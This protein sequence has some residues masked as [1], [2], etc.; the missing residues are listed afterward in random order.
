MLFTPLG[1]LPG[2]K[3]GPGYARGHGASGHWLRARAAVVNTNTD[4]MSRWRHLFNVAKTNFRATGTTG[5]NITPVNGITPAEA[6]F[7]QSAT[8]LG[9]LVPGLFEGDLQLPQTLSGCSSVEAFE[10]M[11]S[12]ILAQLGFP[13]PIAPAMTVA[14][15]AASGSTVT[16]TAGTAT[17]AVSPAANAQVGPITAIFAAALTISGITVPAPPT[18]PAPAWSTSQT[19]IVQFAMLPNSTAQGNL[20]SPWA[21]LIDEVP[22]QYTIAVTGLPTGVTCALSGIPL[23]GPFWLNSPMV[24]QFSVSAT[25]DAAPGAYQGSMVCTGPGGTIS[26]NFAVTILDPTAYTIGVNF[27]GLPTGAVGELEGFAMYGFNDPSPVSLED[28]PSGTHTTFPLTY[29]ASTNTLTGELYFGVT[30]DPS[31]PAST[32]T[33]SATLAGYATAPTVAPQFTVTTVAVTVGQPCPPFQVATSVAAHTVYD[34]DWNVIGFSLFPTWPSE[35]NDPS[36]PAGYSFAYAW[37]LTASPSYTSGYAVPPASQWRTILSTGPNLPTPQQVLAA[38]EDIF[39]PLPPT[40]KMKI[41]FQWVDPLT[42]APGPQATKTLSWAQGTN[43]GA[44]TPQQGWPLPAFSVSTITPGILAPGSTQVTLTV[45]AGYNYTGAISFSVAAASYINTGTPPGADT[46][47]TGLTSSFDNPVINFVNGVPDHASTTLTLSAI[48]GAQQFSGEIDVELTDSVVSERVY[49]T[50]TIAGVTTPQPL[51]NFL[52]M[53]PTQTEIYTPNNSTAALI[54]DLFNSGPLDMQVS[55]LDTYT[56]ADYAIEFAQGGQAAATATPTEITFALATGAATNELTGQYLSSAGYAPAGYNLTDAEIVSNTATTVTVASTNNPAAMTTAGIAGIIDN[57][58]TV[59]AGTMGS[60]GLASCVAFIECGPTFSAPNP[61]LQIVASAGKNTT[62]SIVTT[63]SNPSDGFQMS[64]PIQYVNQPVP[65]TTTVALVFSNT[66]P[67]AV[68][69]T[70]TPYAH[71]NGVTLTPAAGSV[72]IPAA[73]GAVPGTAT[74]NVTVTTTAEADLTQTSPFIQAI[75]GAYSQTASIVFTDT[76]Y[77]PLY[78]SVSPQYQTGSSPG[79]ASATLTVN[80]ASAASATVTLAITQTASGFHASLSSSSV[81]V[82]PGTTAAPTT[83]SVTINYTIDS[84]QS[85]QTG[86]GD[87][88]GTATGYNE[89]QVTYWIT[90]T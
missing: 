11:I 8:Y 79:T 25:P 33:F 58:L 83:A 76:Q 53:S 10:V 41:E 6:W 61:Q 19:P 67:A 50:L 88:N 65:G 52:S 75:S 20:L 1:K 17:L 32:Y 59:P 49:L 35:F 46:I 45:T 28:L 38:W 54:F 12:T 37:T 40:G 44:A 55:M 14:K 36:Q 63:T 74:V 7:Y 47:P 87:V 2:K 84:G 85:G 42:G 9:I 48:A 30:V 64:P 27:A 15:A 51:Y 21:L 13:T 69:A 68:T 18:P 16:T 60:P 90:A 4:A 89:L 31:T 56:G 24:Y 71:G 34:T 77:G 62:Y 29:N 43:K 82:G 26:Y 81:T 80:N 23:P 3:A 5:R 72:T 22:G 73:V 66:N 57:A 70:L 86:G 78:M 39:G